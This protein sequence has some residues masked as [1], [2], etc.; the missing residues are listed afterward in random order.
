[1]E[2]FPDTGTVARMKYN[3]LIHGRPKQLIPIFDKEWMQIFVMTGRGWGKTRTGAEACNHVAR[4]DKDVNR[5][6]I[7]GKTWEDTRKVMIEGKSGILKCSP[8]WFMPEYEPS[9]KELHWPN[10]V[11]GDCYSGDT[12]DKLRGPFQDFAWVD[13]PAKLMYPQEIYDN[14][15]YGLR[16]AIR[17]RVIFTGTPRPTKF[18][19]SLVKDP[20]TLMITGGYRENDILSKAYIE[21]LEYRYAGTRT[22]RQEADGQLLEDNPLALWHQSWLDDNRKAI[23]PSMRTIVVGVDPNSSN[24][25]KSDA[26]GIIVV[27][28]GY[29]GRHYI[30]GDYTT[31]GTPEHRGKQ[32]ARAYKEHEADVIVFEKN[33]GGD[34]V[35]LVLQL[36]CPNSRIESVNA[37]R[38]K[39]TRAHP[40]SQLHERGVS[41]IVGTDFTE[42]E[43]ELTTWFPGELSP[44]RMDAM[45]WAETFLIT[46]RGSGELHEVDLLEE[47]A[48]NLGEFEG[49]F[50]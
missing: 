3:W 2:N 23:A 12:P 42:L 32:V 9:K 8:P 41:H 39:Q 24:T 49:L 50:R 17:P 30:I 25:D 22:Y 16:E 47:Y 45:V 13:E 10:G 43:D 11:Q 38:N 29:D 15:K 6:A 20:R 4:Y 46:L 35:G 44:D 27:G 1:M 28:E 21:D 19:I 14:M 7:I 5:I 33:S 26:M 36:S 48:P 31:R 37:T 34:W 18:V 40:I